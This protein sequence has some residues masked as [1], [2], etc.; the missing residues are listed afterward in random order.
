[1]TK[2]R[3]ERIE[4]YCEESERIWAEWLVDVEDEIEAW[5]AKIRR[6]EGSSDD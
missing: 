4:E 3:D 5:K 6:L 2:S 1:M